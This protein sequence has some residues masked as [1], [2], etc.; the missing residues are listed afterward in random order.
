MTIT[1]TAITPTFAAEIGDR[2]IERGDFAFLRLAI[3]LGERAILW[4]KVGEPSVAI[5]QRRIGP[6]GANAGDAGAEEQSSVGIN[7][8]PF[9]VVFLR[10]KM[11]GRVEQRTALPSTIFVPVGR[12][13]VGGQGFPFRILC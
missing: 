8:V 2:V 9:S 4:R 13:L 6:A 1:I 11:T 5:L 7:E 12:P 3:R 10:A